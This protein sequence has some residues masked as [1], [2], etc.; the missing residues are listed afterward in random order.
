LLSDVFA[1]ATPPAVT[2]DLSGAFGPPSIIY[3]VIVSMTFRVPAL[4]VKTVIN[5]L[6]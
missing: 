4:R 2:F 3:D 5:A 6:R 1:A